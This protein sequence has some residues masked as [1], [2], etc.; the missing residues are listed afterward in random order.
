MTILGLL[1][2]AVAIVIVAVKAVVSGFSMNKVDKTSK[3]IQK[4]ID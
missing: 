4:A 2:T 3:K 1:T